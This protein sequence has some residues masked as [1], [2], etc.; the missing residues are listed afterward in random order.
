MRAESS[1]YRSTLAGNRALFV[2]H[3]LITIYKYN[4]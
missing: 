4:L 1:F 3:M 2:K